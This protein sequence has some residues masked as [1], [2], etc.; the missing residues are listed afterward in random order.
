MIV[1]TKIVIQGD[2][3]RGSAF[4]GDG[5]RYMA[6]LENLMSFQ[7]LS[8]YSIRVTHQPGVTI[9]CSKVFGAKTVTIHTEGGGNQKRVIHGAECWCFPHFSFGIVLEVYPKI[10]DLE[11]PTYAA[12]LEAYEEFLLAKT[13]G[14]FTYDL[15]VCK[16]LS[17]MPLQEVFSYSW[18]RYYVG[19]FVLV[20]PL[21]GVLDNEYPEYDCD[22]KC[23]MEEPKFGKYAISPLHVDG[24]M[25]KW[26]KKWSKEVSD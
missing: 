22:R 12:D 19:Q 18:A 11:D 23:L 25:E 10:P 5:H 1:P 9:H 17:F 24:Q 6:L 13:G 2:K 16:G 4:I 21:E 15:L 8:Q 3:V 7:K 14:M 20:S 26:I